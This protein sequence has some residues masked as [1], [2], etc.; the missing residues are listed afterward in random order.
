MNAAGWDC[1]SLSRIAALLAALAILAERAGSSSFPVR[2]V[3]LAILRR[4]ETVAHGFVVEASQTTWP[5]TEEDLE[6]D[7]RPVDAAWLAWRF[8]LL[9]A[10][11]AALMRLAGRADSWHA[12]VDR[13]TC[14]LASSRAL[15]PCTAWTRMPNDTS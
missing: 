13:A 3:V 6:T 11:L 10:M 2:F 5:Y 9:A 12:G 14:R 8:R 15:M 7:C 4:A 1:R